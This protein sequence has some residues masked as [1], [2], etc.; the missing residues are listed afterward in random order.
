M[1]VS[2]KLRGR[3]ISKTKEMKGE[4]L[5]CLSQKDP[6]ASACRLKNTALNKI[7]GKFLGAFTFQGETS[8]H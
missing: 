7:L 4:D 3:K 1:R 8:E 6:Y 5:I 2:E